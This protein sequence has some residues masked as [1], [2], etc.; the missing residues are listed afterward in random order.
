MLIVNPYIQ[1]SQLVVLGHFMGK[2]YVGV[3]RVKMFVKFSNMGS[4]FRCSYAVINVSIKLQRL[5]CD[6]LALIYRT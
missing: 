4:F 5:S 2:L 3:N 1:E 6:F